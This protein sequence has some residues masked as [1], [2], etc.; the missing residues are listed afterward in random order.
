MQRCVGILLHA[1]FPDPAP[2][3]TNSLVSEDVWLP[4]P[5]PGRDRV[6]SL[7]LA[8]RLQPL[9]VLRLTDPLLRPAPT[10][11]RP[12]RRVDWRMSVTGIRA[13]YGP[14]ENPPRVGWAA[15]C[16]RLVEPRPALD[17]DLN[18]SRPGDRRP[19]ASR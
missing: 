3:P 4:L 5:L 8:C 1:H 6:P 7:R 16:R 11:G 17:I 13:N 12:A 19:E 2:G 9:R 14:V 18:P 10:K 15:V